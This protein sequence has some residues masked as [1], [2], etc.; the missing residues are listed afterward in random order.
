MFGRLTAFASAAAVAGAAFAGMSGMS[1]ASADPGCPDVH[2]FGAAGSGQRDGNLTANAGMGDDVY[3]SFLDLQQLVAAD[4]RTMTAEAVE[5]PAVAVPDDDGG[6]GDWLGFM[7][8]VD[9]GATALNAQYAAFSAKCP[10]S[11]V[12]FAGYSQGAMVV[13]RNL[14]ALGANP[15]VAGALLIADGDRLPTDTTFN[16]GSVTAVPGAGKGVA[17]D[18]PIL[19]RAPQGLPPEIG[20]R[21]ISVCELGDAVCDYDPEAEEVSKVATMIHTSYTTASGGYRWTQPLYQL[22]GGAPV[23]PEA[24]PVTPL[25]ATVPAE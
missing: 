25:G 12:I 5:Y 15:N 3:Q 10:A 18:W 24:Q 11:K 21:T 16:I 4:G 7:G 17:Q 2:W 23:A 20:A 9:T 14:H 13:H 8:S 6:V 19:A 22:L 1:L